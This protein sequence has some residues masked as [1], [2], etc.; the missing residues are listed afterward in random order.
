[1]ENGVVVGVGLLLGVA[2]GV[3]GSV[4]ALRSTPVFV[5]TNTGPP[6][7]SALPV[8]PVIVVL[9]ALGV[10]LVLS[11]FLLAVGIGRLATPDRLREA[12]T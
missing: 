10:A 9:V 5:D 8:L 1:M 7:E 11:S 4:L 2:A 6:V 3:G 12:Q